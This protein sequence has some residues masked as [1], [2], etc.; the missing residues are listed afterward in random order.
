MSCDNMM[1]MLHD[2]LDKTL[3]KDEEQEV[4]NHLRKCQSCRSEYHNMER[5]DNALRQV[6][7]E[8]VADIDVP[9]GL[10]DRIE[11]II[12][13]EKRN[14]LGSRLSVLLK[15]PAVAAA[16]LF[17]VL[18]AGYVTY[19]NYF[20]LANRQKV[21]ISEMDA[22]EYSGESAAMPA[23]DKAGAAVGENVDTLNQVQVLQDSVMNPDDQIRQNP[24]NIEKDQVKEQPGSMA[25][26]LR[27]QPPAPA[28]AAAPKALIKSRSVE[29][30]IDTSVPPGM[31]GGMIASNEGSMIA[32]NGGTM[33]E[34][35]RNVDFIPAKPAYLPQGAVLSNVSWLSGEISQ[36]Y[37]TGKNF[38]T[39]SQSRLEAGDIAYVETLSQVSNVN[40]NGW[41]GFIQER[42]PEPGDN[43]S[44]TI[45]TLRW[46]QSDWVF[47]VSGDLPAEEI[48][49]ISASIK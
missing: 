35:L 34:A 23:A 40:I 46:R 36:D 6:V 19:N 8:M 4:K 24:G 31:G 30:R 17:V 16:L 43:V 11:K 39:V 38:F 5:A 45:T 18:A 33:E 12:S 14:T 26:V 28:D 37:R 22:G 47:S 1:Q 10:S 13:K 2:F 32:S 44:G 21:A 7:C 9:G 48:I 49:R 42:R 20:D 41:L 27:G 29:D 3:S 25:G 15:T